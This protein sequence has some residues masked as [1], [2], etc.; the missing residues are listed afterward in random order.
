ML[1]RRYCS[2]DLWAQ[3][4]KF[5]DFPQIWNLW[6]TSFILC[7]SCTIV[8]S[9]CLINHVFLEI[10]NVKLILVCVAVSISLLQ[11]WFNYKLYQNYC[12]VKLFFLFNFFFFVWAFWM[13]KNW[14]IKRKTWVGWTKWF[15]YTQRHIMT[16]LLHQETHCTWDTL[17]SVDLSILSFLPIWSNY[18][19]FEVLCLYRSSVQIMISRVSA[20]FKQTKNYN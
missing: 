8:F 13:K 1:Y 2:D 15:F 10:S 6:F 17:F 20:N 9:S 19:C 14:K 18:F 12:R 16:S 11:I 5:E 7:S 4:V 3:S